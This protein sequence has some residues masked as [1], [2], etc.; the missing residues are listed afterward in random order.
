MN[1]NNSK[2]IMSFKILI[3]FQQASHLI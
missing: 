3:T 1:N 2:V